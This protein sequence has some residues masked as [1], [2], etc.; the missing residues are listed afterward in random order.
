LKYKALTFR[1]KESTDE[2]IKDGGML[3]LQTTGE[4]TE[5]AQLPIM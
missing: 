3:L 4:A 5:K 2:K 1:L